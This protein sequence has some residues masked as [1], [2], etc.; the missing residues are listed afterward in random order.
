MNLLGESLVDLVGAGVIAVKHAHVPLVGCLPRSVGV[1][2]GDDALILAFLGQRLQLGAVG[3][4]R[5]AVLVEQ[6]FVVPQHHSLVGEGQAVEMTVH[7]AHIQRPGE[8]LLVPAIFRGVV[9]QRQHV[10]GL[11]IVYHESW[12]RRLHDVRPGAALDSRACHTV[13]VGLEQDLEENVGM[14]SVES[15]HE[16]PQQRLAVG[17]QQ[18][19]SPPSHLDHAL[20][21]GRRRWLCFFGRR[22]RWTRAQQQREGEQ[23]RQ[24]QDQSLIH[25]SPPSASHSE[26]YRH[27][28]RRLARVIKSITCSGLLICPRTY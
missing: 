3:G 28:A 22:R 19:L 2:E 16:I 8:N 21:Q 11:D 18:G 25:R 10:V 12:P 17:P 14:R 27:R 9:V 24:Y 23:C 1:S 7:L 6:S 4:R 20:R 13:Q 5:P 15:V 26:T